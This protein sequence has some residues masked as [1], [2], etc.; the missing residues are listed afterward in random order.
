MQAAVK[1][2]VGMR[3][4]VGGLQFGEGES[5]NSGI[6]D[7]NPPISSSSAENHSNNQIVS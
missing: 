1:T 7:L 6:N 5:D 2:V 3:A 4:A